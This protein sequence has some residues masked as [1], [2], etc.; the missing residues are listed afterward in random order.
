MGG[1]V[2]LKELRQVWRAKVVE[3]FEGEEYIFE[4]DAMF[5]EPDD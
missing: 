3:G 1:C 5:G 2:E 4:V